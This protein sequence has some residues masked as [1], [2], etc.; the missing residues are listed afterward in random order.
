MSIAARRLVVA[1]AFGLAAALAAH[2]WRGYGVDL[3]TVTGI[4]FGLLAFATHRT[5][6]RL[7]QTVGRPDG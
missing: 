1:V 7:R 2:Y 4:S 3:S 6:E 5:I